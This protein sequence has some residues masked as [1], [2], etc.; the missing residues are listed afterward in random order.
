MISYEDAVDV[1][2]AEGSKIRLEHEPV[3]VA[4][5]S[6][7]ICAEA[8]NAPIA[9]QPFDNSAM[10]G[11]ALRAEDVVKATHDNPVALEILA[12]IAAG[13]SGQL[14]A[15]GRG[16]CYEIMTGAPLP[17]G[18]DCVIQVEKTTKEG[19]HAFFMSTAQKGENIRRTGED[20]KAGDLVVKAGTLLHAG[21]VLALSTL[22][23]DKI[24]A[25]KRPS[26]TLISTGKEV[27]DEPGNT[28]NP[29]QIYNS[30]RPYLRTVMSTL[31]IDAHCGGNV[32]DD[33][34]AFAAKIRTMMKD[35]IDVGI[36]TG[37]VSAG[38]HDFVPSILKD[39]GAEIFFHKVA[40]KPGKPII[41]AKLPGNM[42]FFGLPGNPV[43]SA[44]GFRFFVAPALRAI[45]GLPPEK[46]CYAILKNEWSKKGNLR[47][48]VRVRTQCTNRGVIE[49][50]ILPKQQSFMVGMFTQSDA[51][52]VI[53]ENAEKLEAGTVVQIFSD[54]FF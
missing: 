33:A 40:I 25:L 7:R 48:F 6:R 27:V 34:Q 2:C 50:E 49:A 9:N 37:A 38:V 24:N 11:Y 3:L 46:A 54:N 39:L 43:S 16:Q 31:G 19:V 20:I 26:V 45:Q 29:G 4:N 5:L 36:S 17:P 35:K 44:V 47:H 15:A 1:I 8:I 21:H 13:D 18:C 10:D 32:A 12:H 30:T 22:G 42:L 41:F 51:W 52:A 28:L 53:P 23:I 14:R